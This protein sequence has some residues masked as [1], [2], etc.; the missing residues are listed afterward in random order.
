MRRH[1]ILSTIKRAQ[2]SVKFKEID[3]LEVLMMKM[4]SHLTYLKKM[5]EK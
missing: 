1:F 3:L 2:T 4:K 5:R